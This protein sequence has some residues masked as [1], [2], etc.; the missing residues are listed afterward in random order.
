MKVGDLVKLKNGTIRIIM[1]VVADNPMAVAIRGQK[2]Y[3]A[4]RRSRCV[5]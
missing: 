5:I 3:T 1:E 4:G 2:S